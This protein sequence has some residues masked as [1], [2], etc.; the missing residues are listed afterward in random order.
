M[1]L[2]THFGVR[3]ICNWMLKSLFFQTKTV[4]LWLVC[5]LISWPVVFFFF[6]R[7]TLVQAVLSELR[8]YSRV[9]DYLSFNGFS[10]F[11]LQKQ[12]K[13]MIPIK[14]I[15]SEIC[16]WEDLKATQ[17][18]NWFVPFF[19][20]LHE[21]FFLSPSVLCDCLHLCSVIVAGY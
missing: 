1:L 9:E 7:L 10:F 6:N 4:I 8:L 21:F 11:L 13:A 16:W 3:N 17:H 20:V 18:C 2:E 5:G 12:I 19:F 14:N 15:S